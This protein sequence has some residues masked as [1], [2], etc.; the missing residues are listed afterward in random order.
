MSRRSGIPESTKR[1]ARRQALDS[2][3]D[4][5]Y[6]RIVRVDFVKRCPRRPVPTA[7]IKDLADVRCYPRLEPDGTWTALDTQR[8]RNIVASYK[9]KKPRT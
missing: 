2:W 3:K 5:T 1:K 7:C 8:T 9:A 4:E 6:A